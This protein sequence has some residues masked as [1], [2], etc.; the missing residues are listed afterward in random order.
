[1]VMT[2]RFTLKDAGE[3]V[4]HIEPG[5][6]NMAFTDLPGMSLQAAKPYLKSL[7][8]GGQQVSSPFLIRKQFEKTAVS[9]GFA[10][11]EGR[12]LDVVKAIKSGA[13]VKVGKTT[14]VPDPGL[15]EEMVATAV[16]ATAIPEGVS[17]VASMD[18]T[19][20]LA[21]MFGRALAEKAGAEFVD[22][23]FIRSRAHL[24]LPQDVEFKKRPEIERAFKRAEERGGG[25][26]Q[27]KHFPKQF[28][29]FVGYDVDFNDRMLD[30][31]TA[32][33]D[34]EELIK[35]LLVDDVISTGNTLKSV[36]AELDQ[37]P[38][39][40]IGVVTMFKTQET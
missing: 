31:M 13:P 16:A 8:G 37:D 29:H 2:E 21:A 1:M 3:D 40:V 5:F 4:W 12:P 25:K 15:V 20:Q 24:Q 26:F 27:A 33:E 14:L 38:F 34:A 19:S 22:A 36:I 23:A 11:P 17:L 18:S 28:Q 6:T 32:P 39:E 7:R 10:P 9:D 30:M 35:V